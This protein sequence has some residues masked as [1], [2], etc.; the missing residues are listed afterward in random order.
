MTDFLRYTGIAFI[1]ASFTMPAAYCEMISSRDRIKPQLT[2][3]ERGGIWN[4]LW[5][6]TCGWPYP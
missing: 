6:G 5:G 1:I 2:C 3:I 4:P